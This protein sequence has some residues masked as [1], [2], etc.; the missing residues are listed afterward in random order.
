[1]ECVDSKKD[2]GELTDSDMSMEHK[3]KKKRKHKHKHK[4]D[5]FKDKVDG[6]MDK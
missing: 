4:K 1:M 3:K 2:P 6:K 5:N